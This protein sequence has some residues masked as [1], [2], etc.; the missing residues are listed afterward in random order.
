MHKFLAIIQREYLQRV[1]TKMFIIFTIL[2]PLLM[3]MFTVLPGL[4]FAIKTGEATRLAVVDQSGKLYGRVRESLV[5]ERRDEEE[6]PE[7]ATPTPPSTAASET[8]QQRMRR[9]GK[10]L[11]GSYLVEQVPVN[12]RPV[13]EIRKDLEAR[14]EKNQLDGYIIIPQNVDAGDKFEYYARNVSDMITR[15]QIKSSLNDAVRDQRLAEAN[16][17]QERMHDINK[18]I[19]F[20]IRKAGAGGGEEDSGGGFWLVFIIGFL[21][22]IMIIMYGQVILAAVI[23]E[24]ETR[25]AEILF[26][27]V[28]SFHLML[29]K[30][31]GIS[32]VALTQ[33]A[34]W[35]LVALVFAVYGV[36]VLASNDINITLP[37]IAPSVILYLFIFFLMGYFVY[38]T[39]YALVGSMVTT[40]Q[41]GGQVAM[42]VMFMLIIGFYMAFP[43]IRSPN[44]SF[45]FWVSMFPFFSPI[46]MPVRIITQTPP[47][48][49]IALSLA[50][51]FATIIFLVWLASRIYRVGMLMYGKRATIPEVMRWIRQA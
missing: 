45:A 5:N 17:S 37:H 50:I 24:K 32:L 40:T 38:A 10:S 18:D 22:Y 20:N 21:I 16:I 26:S 42:P 8:T 7:V 13:D 28:R 11:I 34:I 47:F 6:K 9:A 1:K 43:V 36:G 49:Q 46:T 30:L 31:I 15:E 41:E 25:I 3:A 35:G 4:I 19:A 29:G 14:I 39:I 2:G 12:G 51:G 27:S 48:W 33:Y 23:E 44:S